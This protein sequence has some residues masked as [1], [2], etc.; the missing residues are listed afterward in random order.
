MGKA[1][2]M[3]T[4]QNKALIYAATGCKLP[5]A[6]NFFFVPLLRQTL[7]ESLSRRGDEAAVFRKDVYGEPSRAR[8]PT[9]EASSGYSEAEEHDQWEGM[10]AE[11][12]SIRAQ[13]QAGH[14][15]I[16]KVPL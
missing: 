9:R 1:M 10:K 14:Q 5:E 4:L 8:S 3:T 15:L 13:A 7:L 11:K 12:L 6:S 2:M 16:G